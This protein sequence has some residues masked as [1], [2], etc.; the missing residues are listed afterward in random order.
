MTAPPIYLPT[1]KPLS[2][3]EAVYKLVTA[4]NQLIVAVLHKPIHPYL[5]WHAWN[6]IH[7]SK[8]DQPG[9]GMI[10]SDAK[11]RHTFVPTIQHNE[12]IFTFA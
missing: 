3:I 12:T 6:P 5:R 1:G 11:E 2:I 7:T 9:P 10:E 4:P 8:R